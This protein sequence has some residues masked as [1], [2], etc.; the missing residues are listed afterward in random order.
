M[1]ND[2]LIALDYIDPSTLTYGEWLAVGMDLCANG[3]D[4]GTWENW[5]M[6]DTRYKNGV[7]KSKWRSFGSNVSGGTI[8]GMAVKSGYRPQT[9]HD[10]T[11][12]RRAPRKPTF[13]N[14]IDDIEPFTENAFKWELNDVVKE[15]HQQLLTCND[16]SVRTTYNGQKYDIT[17]LTYLTRVRKIP[18]EVIERKQIGYALN[19]QNDMLV[20]YPEY[21][22][23]NGATAQNHRIVFPFYNGSDG[24]NY[25]MTETIN[26]DVQTFAGT[27]ED[28]QPIYNKIQKY[29]KPKSDNGTPETPATVPK[30]N[31]ELYNEYLLKGSDV[32]KVTFIVEGIYDA[33]SVETVGGNAIVLTGTAHRRFISICKNYKPD[34]LF[35]VSLDNDGPGKDAIKRITDGLT[36]LNLRY[37]KCTAPEPYK[38]FNECLQNDRDLLA[39]FVAN[40]SGTTTDAQLWFDNFKAATETEPKK[41]DA[42][43]TLNR[44]LETAKRRQNGRK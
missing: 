28:G 16:K 43:K 5:S 21:K 33:L 17:P 1:E 30:V 24:Y 31:A 2:L 9:F 35:I 12:R 37:K 41:R 34:T 14:P 23:S 6:N 40:A 22:R 36:A 18:L 27:D 13:N 32:P 26:R 44:A 8:I 10:K 15:M 19:G 3:Y 29:L 42:F 4:V 38:D 20:N 7:C 25:F 39:R 11:N